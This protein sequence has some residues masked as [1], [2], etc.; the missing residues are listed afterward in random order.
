MGNFR[1]NFKTER[2]IAVSAL[3]EIL[4]KGA[5]SNLVLREILARQA[6]LSRIQKAFVTEIVAG[7][8][9]NLFLLDHIIESFSSA[10]LKKIKPPI[11]CILR[12]SV[13][14]L[15][16]M[17][18]VPVFAIC[19]EAVKITRKLGFGGLSGFVNGVLRSIA[20]DVSGGSVNMPDCLSKRYSVQE[21]IV[22]HFYDE[23]GLE[24]TLELLKAIMEPPD[25]AVCI[26]TTK[27]TSLE[28]TEILSNEGIIVSDTFLPNVLKISKTSDMSALESFRQGLY[29][30]MDLSA[31]LAMLCAFNS[32]KRIIDLCAAPG[33]K[34][35]L[36]AYL[37]GGKAEILARDIY[38]HKIKLI[39]AGAKRLGLKNIKAEL[40]DGRVFCKELEE[41]ADLV[42]LDAPCSGLGTLRKRPDIKIG[43]Q[44]DSIE[45]LAKMSREI[46]EGSWR[47]VK[48]G[49]RLVF[50]TCTISNAEN[51]D[52]FKW[53]LNNFPFV[54]VDFKDKLSEFMD[55][56]MFHVEHLGCLQILPQDFGG[57]GFFIGVLER[58]GHSDVLR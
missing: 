56:R 40:A 14:Q 43:K 51:L 10:P 42:I 28:L 4:E 2:E 7:C 39:E 24:T 29:H 37:T 26:N 49:G 5:Y 3:L 30:V 21:W 55:F 47:Y 9:R 53:F 22:R 6:H 13:Y 17:D 46:F 15:K 12:I 19:D 11:L 32:P 38:P 16:F 45:N 41:T 33:G 58:V 31:V 50:A 54:A 57:D 20:R 52:N 1:T 44:E 34:T 35:F 8:I 36:S 18:K 25:V 48:V 23:L 27:T